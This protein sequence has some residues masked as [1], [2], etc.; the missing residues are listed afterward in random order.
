MKYFLVT[1]AMILFS[2]VMVAQSTEKDSYT[3][4][5]LLLFND[6]DEILLE[7]H[8]NGWMTPALRHQEKQSTNQGLYTLATDFGYEISRPKLA[9]I[10]TFIPEYKNQASFRQYYRAQMIQGQLQLPEGK[11]DA[12]WFSKEKALEMLALPDTKII[13]AVRD[14]TQQ[15]LNRPEHIWGGSYRLWKEAGKT[16]YRLSEDFY[17]ME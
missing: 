4:Q 5:R 6:K 2:S 12:Q 8:P 11:I 9:G 3:I 1:T 17:I 7:K 13:F 10:F 14:M 15:V 16:K